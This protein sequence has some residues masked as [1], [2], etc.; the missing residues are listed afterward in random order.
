MKKLTSMTLAANATANDQ[1]LREKMLL[2][3]GR[4]AR[5]I[6]LRLSIPI[7]RTGSSGAM[8]ANEKLALLDLFLFS[9][10]VGQKGDFQ[11]PF[12]QHSL[13]KIRTLIRACAHIDFGY[14]TDANVGFA[15][16]L[17]DATQSILKLDVLIPTGRIEGLNGEEK[18]LFGIGPSQLYQTR[19]KLEKTS[20]TI[21]S[22]LAISGAIQIDVLTDDA[23]CK[24]DRWSILPVYNEQEETSLRV[25]TED[26][27]IL[28]CAEYT[29]VQASS[30]LANV[31]IKVDAEVISEGVGV[32]DFF[33]QYQSEPSVPVSALT[34]DVETI[35]HSPVLLGGRKLRQYPS[36][37]LTIEQKGGRQQ[38][39]M[40]VSS[41]YI[42]VIEKAKIDAE[43]EAVAANVR[44]KPVKAVSVV[45]LEG[46]KCPDRL[47]FAM[48]FAFVDQ[49]DKE[50]E[51]LPGIYASPDEKASDRVPTALVNRARASLAT[52]GENLLAARDV[53]RRVAVAI[54]GA[55][56]SSRGFSQGSTAALR[57]VD[58]LIRG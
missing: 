53:S 54:P 42:P 47:R 16:A 37:A 20:N 22:G 40:K 27:L 58:A 9:M 43:V 17:V 30:A 1:V 57:N 13:R 8:T 36:G 49:Q 24:F 21:A 34:S 3:K 19:L 56:E 23:P 51:M 41:F 35:I 14:Y 15:F 28:H 52:H 2:D 55:S 26:G 39:S 7:T 6:R 46:I 44:N 10:F 32:N 5:D 12:S 11:R 33:P 29:A 25:K 48:P 31:D 18:D 4:I 50:Y 45:E 38:A